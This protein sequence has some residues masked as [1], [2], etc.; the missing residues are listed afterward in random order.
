MGKISETVF[1]YFMHTT[2]KDSNEEEL[3]KQGKTR[4]PIFPHIPSY[5]FSF[6]LENFSCNRCRH[7]ENHLQQ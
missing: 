5:T 7:I 6:S 4:D 3:D 2:N 1:L